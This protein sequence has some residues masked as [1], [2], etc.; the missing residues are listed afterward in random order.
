MFWDLEPLTDGGSDC[1]GV[2]GYAQNP[3]GLSVSDIRSATAVI[4]DPQGKMTGTI[5]LPQGPSER[6]SETMFTKLLPGKQV[7]VCGS[8]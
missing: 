7:F 3:G 2:I 6:G 5:E 1:C 8:A 4:L